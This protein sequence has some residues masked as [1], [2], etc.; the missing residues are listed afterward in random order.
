MRPAGR[1]EKHLLNLLVKDFGGKP[2]VEQLEPV[3]SRR[4]L[5]EVSRGQKRD[6]PRDERR[7]ETVRNMGPAA[8][9]RKEQFIELVPG[10]RSR[11]PQLQVILSSWESVGQGP[12]NTEALC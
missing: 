10:D 9:D 8:G 2:N 4:E 5:V 6:G 7:L 1:R 11:P 3:G 12:H